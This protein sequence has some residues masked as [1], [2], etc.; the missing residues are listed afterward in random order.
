MELLWSKIPNASLQS[1]AN[2]QAQRIKL[3]NKLYA[4][5]SPWSIKEA[6]VRIVGYLADDL[7]KS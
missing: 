4:I 3:L 7:R 5:L 6:Q 2:L 1:H